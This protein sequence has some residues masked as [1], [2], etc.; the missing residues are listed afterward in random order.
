MGRRVF[1][2]EDTRFSSGAF[3]AAAAGFSPDAG[4]SSSGIFAET[5]IFGLGFSTGTEAGAAGGAAFLTTT[6]TLRRK[7]PCPCAAFPGGTDPLEPPPEDSCSL[8]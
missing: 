4:A 8:F 2:M 3:T 5:T 1:G 6:L 7:S